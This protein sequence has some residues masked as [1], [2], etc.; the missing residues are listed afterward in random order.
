[1]LQQIDF[2]R[3]NK[4]SFKGRQFHEISM[5]LYCNKSISDTIKNKL[6]NVV[7][8]KLVI[9]FNSEHFPDDQK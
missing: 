7:P 2:L 5:F 4:M 6:I 9:G 1:M 8:P 3:M